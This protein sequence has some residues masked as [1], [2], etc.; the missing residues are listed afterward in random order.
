MKVKTLFKTLYRVD[1]VLQSTSGQT[2][3]TDFIQSYDR[4]CGIMA[5]IYADW[6]V[7]KITT[8]EGSA[9]LYITISER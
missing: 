9:T 7:K 4:Y 8:V 5:D 1:Y 2:L 6:I 3:E